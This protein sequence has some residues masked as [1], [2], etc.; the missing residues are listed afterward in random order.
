MRTCT[1]AAIM[2]LCVLNGC[3]LGPTYREFS[4]TLA[5]VPTGD[6]RVFFYRTSIFGA[7]L[8]PAILVNGE[9]VGTS[10]AGG[11]FYVD[12]PAGNYT[13]H[14]SNEKNRVLSLVLDPGAVYFVRFRAAFPASVYPELVDAETAKDEIANCNY[15]PPK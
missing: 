10:I 7:T 8:Q 3:G 6:G 11:F 15:T 13:I 4:P 5:P 14:A 2:I 9:K 12:R 1:L